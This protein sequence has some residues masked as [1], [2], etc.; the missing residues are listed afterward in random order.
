MMTSRHS[1][2][3]G[4][5]RR[6]SSGQYGDH[7]TLKIGAIQEVGSSEDPRLKAIAKEVL[8]NYGIGW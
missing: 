8:E 2:I 1:R 3:Q 4:S 6:G 7:L 5:V